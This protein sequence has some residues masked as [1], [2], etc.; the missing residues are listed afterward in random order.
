MLLLNCMTLLA[1][2]VSVSS[3]QATGSVPVIVGLTIAPIITLLLT[4]K[5]VTPE[6][7]IWNFL[8]S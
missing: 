8:A 7:C 3:M 2:S 6:I 4:V 1:G 5:A